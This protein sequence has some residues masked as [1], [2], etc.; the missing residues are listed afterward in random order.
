MTAITTQVLISAHGMYSDLL[1]IL[2]T[3]SDYDQTEVFF[4]AAL[5][6]RGPPPNKQRP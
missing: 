6:K 5:L 2:R 1:T 4:V 3:N